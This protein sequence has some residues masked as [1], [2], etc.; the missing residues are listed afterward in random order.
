MARGKSRVLV[1]TELL[2]FTLAGSIFHR[3]DW[4][5]GTRLTKPNKLTPKLTFYWCWFC[6]L[7]GHLLG[8]SELNAARLICGRYLFE[9]MGFDRGSSVRGTRA[10]ADHTNGCPRL[11]VGY[12]RDRGLFYF[13]R[14]TSIA[15]PTDAV[16]EA[17]LFPS[18]TLGTDSF[19]DKDRHAAGLNL[20][21][22]CPLFGSYGSI[23]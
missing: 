11:P 8:V 19:N 20:D 9:E 23:L 5:R 16:V 15:S 14:Y 18:T 17:R 13:P 4:G 10:Y 21:K 12:S 6:L 1:R 3:L 2:I 7:G 22:Q